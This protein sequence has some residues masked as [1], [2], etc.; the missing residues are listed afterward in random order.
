VRT[1]LLLASAAA[2]ALLPAAAVAG[3]PAAA[4]IRSLWSVTYQMGHP[5]GDVSGFVDATC[6]AGF[7]MD[8]RFFPLQRLSAGLA[9]DW[10]RYDETFPMLTQSTPDGAVSGPVYRYVDT[11][12]VRATAHWYPLA[13]AVRPYLGVGIGGI[14]TYQYQQSADLA[15]TDTQFGLTVGPDVGVVVAFAQGIAVDAGAAWAWTP[16]DLGDTKDAQWLTWRV[17]LAWFY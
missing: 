10:T 12:S 14:W 9:T 11:F 3:E 17:G 16:A 8:A 7:R 4:P 15:R 2:V 5:T 13:G 6:W 1:R